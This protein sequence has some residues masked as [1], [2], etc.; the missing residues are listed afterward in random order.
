MRSV[1][2]TLCLLAVSGVLSACGEA[3]DTPAAPAAAPDS[4]PVEQIGA[5]AVQAT[6]EDVAEAIRCHLVL[7]GAMARSISSGGPPRRYGPAVRHWHAQIETRARTA[8]LDEAA[9]DAL[10]RE[11][12]AADRGAGDGDERS[13]F[14]EACFTQSPPE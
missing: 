5:P 12:I 13:A 14:G 2:P 6:R 4:A 7:S 8:G 11:V 10:R 1:F 9:L 3:T